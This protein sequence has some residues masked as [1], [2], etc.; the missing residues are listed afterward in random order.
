MA[1]CSAKSKNSG[2]QCKKD[3][4]DG[5][6]VCHMHV[7][8]RIHTRPG[9]ASI[10]HG[11]YA[12]TYSAL[13]KD[14][15]SEYLLIDNPTSLHSELALARALAQVFMDQFEP[16]RQILGADKTPITPEDG[17]AP[18]FTRPAQIPD[19]SEMLRILETI[20]KTAERIHKM[21]MSNAVPIPN[22]YAVIREMGAIMRKFCAEDQ[23]D[24][25]EAE[26]KTIRVI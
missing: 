13:I 2:A 4:L 19:M 6:D 26:W 25:I 1:R 17:M 5:H 22:M 11:K 14:L 24:A 10:V 23:V 9:S 20:G 12:K 18:A 3:A 15:Q 7:A 21:E 8:G 16:M